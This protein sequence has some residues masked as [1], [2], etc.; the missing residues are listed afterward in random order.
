MERIL[1]VCCPDIGSVRAAVEGGADRIELCA[2]L[3]TGGVTPSPALIRE[4]V[5]LLPGRVNV[6]VRPRGGDFLYT[7]DEV[8]VIL[9]DIEYA[10]AAGAAGIVCGALTPEG[11]V[12][13]DLCRRMREAAGDA[14]FTFHRAID[15]CRDPEGAVDTLVNAGCDRVLTSG[16]APD[17][18]SGAATIA[19]MKRRG[20]GRIIILAGG[21]VTCGN[22]AELLRLTGVSEVHA[23][24]KQSVGSLMIH[25][26]GGVSMGTPGADEYL[27]QETS[28]AIVAELARKIHDFH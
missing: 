14:S 16:G 4:A 12:D 22:V 3:E 8:D 15:L 17:V 13:I 6:L 18:I 5:A 7:A 27:R 9:G 20:E 10:V 26:R 19:S 23:S 21:G 25:R 2:S 28:P 11:D 1:E 24:C